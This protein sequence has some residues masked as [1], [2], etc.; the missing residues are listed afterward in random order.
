MFYF[1][2]CCLA[3]QITFGGTCTYIADQCS[4]VQGISCIGGKC[5]CDS[6]SQ[7]WSVT[8]SKCGA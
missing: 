1:V 3:I 7:A 2:F 6:S 5:I 8:Y 4:T